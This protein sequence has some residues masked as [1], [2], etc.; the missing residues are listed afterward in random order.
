MPEVAVSVKPVTARVAVVEPVPQDDTTPPAGAA[1]N[2]PAPFA[3]WCDWAR[4]GLAKALEGMKAAGGGVTEYHIGSRGLRREGSKSQVDN[5]AYW[6]D[7][8]VF[9]CG[10]TGL[11]TT[12]TGRDTACRIVPRDL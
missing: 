1:G 8:V 2:P 5:V 12:I 9:Y 7:M 6:N 10:D 3:S 4:D 11:P